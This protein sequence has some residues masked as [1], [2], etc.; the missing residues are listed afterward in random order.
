MKQT[1]V[2]LL[3]AACLAGC[4]QDVPPEEFLYLY[5]RG[6]TV[7]A[8]DEGFRTRYLGTDRG[9]HVLDVRYDTESEGAGAMLLW[10]PYRDE[11]LRCPAS[12]LP[13]GFPDDFQTLHQSELLAGERTESPEQTR[14]YV[15]RYLRRGGEG[16]PMRHWEGFEADEQRPP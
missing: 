13:P 15:E 12:E 7:A 11:T 2:P 10:G 5:R 8:R 4:A 16:D 1:L 14:R 9:M 3:L 6:A